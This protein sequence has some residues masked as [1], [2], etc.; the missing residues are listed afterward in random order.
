M[1]KAEVESLETLQ[2]SLQQNPDSLTFARVADALMNTGRLDEA[3]RICEEG[4]RRHPYYV[5]GHM[6]L[7][8]CYMQ[9]KYYDQAEKEFKRVLLYDPKYIAAH[10]YY[11][12]LMREIGWD[13]TCE[14]SYR[15][16]LHMD[17]L[18]QNVQNIVEE[19]ARKAEINKPAAPP[20][21][22]AGAPRETAAPAKPPKPQA[23][24]EA[25]VI[26]A[27]KSPRTAP[28]APPAAP[29]TARMPQAEAPN[30]DLEIP[31]VKRPAPAAAEPKTPA[32]TKSDEARFSSILDD[33]FQDEMM[34]EA[35]SGVA[36]FQRGKSDTAALP[37][38]AEPKHEEAAPEEDANWKPAA[39]PE[40]LRAEVKS[41]NSPVPRTEPT[42]TDLPIPLPSTPSRR[43]PVELD[44]DLDELAAAEERVWAPAPMERR[45]TESLAPLPE[46]SSGSAK[47]ADS[48]TLSLAGLREAG[49]RDKI[50]TPTLGEIYAAQGQYAKA[51]GV[52]ELLS[53]KD[54]TN[55]SYREKI[56]YLKKRLQETQ[57]AG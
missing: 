3:I 40:K 57:N 44:I 49:G 7:G 23:P 41:T 33:I 18:D 12:N 36:A 16:I 11:G 47:T 2:V 4:I 13:N 42:K 54:P 24:R 29:P 8:K 52:F 5:T 10:R 37:P 27:E 34:D 50:V 1:S 35:A 30:G 15:K 22:P 14:M 38:A 31:I 56:D 19:F 53:K 46:K 25:P 17:P 26:A 55:R 6:V 48:E 21:P 28:V 43:R 51:I 39:R 32:L 20:I 45:P 9:K